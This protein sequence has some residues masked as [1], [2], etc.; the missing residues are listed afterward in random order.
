MIWLNRVT[1]L[2]I[3]AVMTGRSLLSVGQ[4][5]PVRP[6]F[7]VASVKPISSDDKRFDI[8]DQPGGRFMA[9]GIPLKMLI[10]F[11]YRVRDFPSVWR[12]GMAD[13]RPLEC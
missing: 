12:T 11:A 13:H 1:V 4:S 5:A 8:R 9:T 10:T 3:L 6:T 2:L 7:E